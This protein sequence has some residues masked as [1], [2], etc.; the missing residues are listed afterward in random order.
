MFKHDRRIDSHSHRAQTPT[1]K[2]VSYFRKTR[3]FVRFNQFRIETPSRFALAKGNCVRL[4]S[5]QS[6]KIQWHPRELLSKTKDLRETFSSLMILPQVHLRKPCYDFCPVQATAI[7]A[8][9]TDAKSRKTRHQRSPLFSKRL[10]PGQ[11]RA[12]CTKGRDVI[13][14]S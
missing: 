4:E 10:S 7:K 14:V 8:V 11:R 2:T 3:T 1:G 6:A 12:V 5:R 13:S 9:S